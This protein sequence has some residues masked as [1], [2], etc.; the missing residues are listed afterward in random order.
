MVCTCADIKMAWTR[1]DRAPSF[2]LLQ[3]RHKKLHPQWHA[4]MYMRRQPPRVG[5]L[6]Y[7]ACL[8]HVALCAE[9]CADRIPKVPIRY[10]SKG[11][12]LSCKGTP[13]AYHT[14]THLPGYNALPLTGPSLLAC[15][16]CERS[17]EGIALKVTRKNKKDEKVVPRFTEALS[18]LSRHERHNGKAISGDAHDGRGRG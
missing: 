3:K 6:S 9:W 16:H 4:C 17:P 2:L 10:Y 7:Y 5:V 13:N 12:F 15:R 18:N 14:H 8:I 1:G 11:R